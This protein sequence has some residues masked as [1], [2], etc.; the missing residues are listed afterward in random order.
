MTL[1]LV[2]TFSLTAVGIRYISGTEWPL[3]WTHGYF[4]LTHTDDSVT[5]TG[6]SQGFERPTMPRRMSTR[7]IHNEACVP[8]CT[9]M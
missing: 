4:C 3:T 1:R 9:C 2:G 5:G 6:T 8:G 7:I